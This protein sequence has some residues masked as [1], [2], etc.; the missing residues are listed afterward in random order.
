MK[1]SW[2]IEQQ[3]FSGGATMFARYLPLPSEAAT[4]EAP[5][6][7]HMVFQIPLTQ[8][9]TKD[10]PCLRT[11]TEYDP[12]DE[13]K[14][15]TIGAATSAAYTSSSPTPSIKGMGVSCAVLLLF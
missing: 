1:A 3:S 9:R 11:Q 12:S 15:I 4:E 7:P 2:Q 5:P 13:W 14:I 10:T 8:L 6:L